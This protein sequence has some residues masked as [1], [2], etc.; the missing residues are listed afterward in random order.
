M[1]VV[2]VS[3]N[4]PERWRQ[5]HAV[6]GAPLPFFASLFSGGRGSPAG[7]FRDTSNAEI[8]SILAPGTGDVRINFERTA[9]GAVLYFRAL[10]ETWAIPLRWDTTT[11][12]RVGDAMELHAHGDVLLIDVPNGRID[13]LERWLAISFRSAF[14]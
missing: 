9:E 5:V 6:S 7:R 1:L 10:L 2:N 3:Y 12:V 11:A 4:D 8:K 13:Q 14:V